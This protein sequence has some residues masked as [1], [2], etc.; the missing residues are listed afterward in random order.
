MQIQGGE[1]AESGDQL[2]F[3]NFYLCP[4]D[5]THWT[6]DW[7]ATCNDR[8]PKCGLEIEPYKSEDL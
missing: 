6:D 1:P 7:S 2:L 8:C 4:E 3:L 5:G